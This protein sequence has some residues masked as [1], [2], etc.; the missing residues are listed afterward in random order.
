MGASQP[1]G[2]VAEVLA[3]LDDFEAGM[4]NDPGLVDG[5]LEPTE[6]VAVR[7]GP[8]TAVGMR[9]DS[10]FPTVTAIGPTG[11]LLGTD[12]RVLVLGAGP[13]ERGG[14]D[15]L[16]EWSWSDDVANMRF[17]REGIGLAW[18][19]RRDDVDPKAPVLGL[20]EPWYAKRERPDSPPGRLHLVG[21]WKLE[22]AW[23]ANQ[24]GGTARWRQDLSEQYRSS[25]EE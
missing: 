1:A 9:P 19:P 2:V 14:A 7:T 6:K 18:M 12:R 5:T 10:E 11:T 22:G 3:W 13:G 8:Y 16:A 15:V 20:V 23:R 21:L 4:I 24:P 25:A 17:I